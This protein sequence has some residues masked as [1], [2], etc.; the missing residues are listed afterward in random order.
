MILVVAAEQHSK[1]RKLQSQNLFNKFKIIVVCVV[2]FMRNHVL[3]LLKVKYSFTVLDKQLR[4]LKW[5]AISAAACYLFG[6]LLIL[7]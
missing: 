1:T 4:F 6:I 7:L 5:N 3:V 2:F